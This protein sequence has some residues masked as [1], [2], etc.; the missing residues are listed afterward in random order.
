MLVSHD[1]IEG[2]IG[3]G[4]L[5]WHAMRAARALLLADVTAPSVRI[6]RLILGRELGQCCGGVVQLWLE[7]FT[8]ADLPLLR[9][10]AGAISGGGTVVVL[11]ELSGSHATRQLL[12]PSPA[13]PGNPPHLRYSATDEHSASLLERVEAV[14]PALWL[15]G[16]GHVGQALVHVLAGL[17]VQITWID[18]R[19]ELLPDGLPDNVHA[20]HAQTPL[21]TVPMAPGAAR[22]LVLTHDHALDYA[23]CRAILARGDFAWLGLIGSQSKGA[24]FRSRLARDGI[25][26]ETI[27]RLVCPIGVEGITSKWPAAIAIGVAAQ[28]LQSL[29]AP[30]APGPGFAAST[31]DGL[32]ADGDC[33]SRDCAACVSSQGP[34][35]RG[36]R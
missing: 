12:S 5:E 33:S 24:R 19:A 8:R 3:G 23:L 17:P 9:I 32:I 1:D 34:Q 21:D 13:H 14:T 7:R 36:A 22:Y 4:R 28:L 25:A 18:P 29:S 16:A 35:S 2:T 10:A 20:L 31:T 6:R 26:P 27:G 15:Y 30:V 11:T